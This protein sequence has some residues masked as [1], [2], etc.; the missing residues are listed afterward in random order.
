MAVEAGLLARMQFTGNWRD[1]QRRALD[2]F[3]AESIGRRIHVVAPPGSGKTVLGLELVRRLG[4]PPLILAPTRTIRDQW[5]SRLCPLFLPQRPAEQDISFSLEQAAPM[6]AITY[7]A[8]HGWWSD[9]D[10]S[11]F[12]AL[13]DR[14][15]REGPVTLVL[16]EAHHLRREW[17][18]ALQALVDALDDARIVALTATPP[19]DAPLG[20]WARYAAM[21]GPVDFEIGVPELV[22][23]GDLCPHQDHVIFSAP[24]RDT[25][26]LL[27][28]RRRGMAALQADLRADGDLLDYLAAHPWLSDP[29]RHA[30]QI[31]E[32]PEILSA[33]LVHFAAAGRRLPGAPL[34][35]LG[36][37]RRELPMPDA[38]WLEI[39][40]DA[41]LF[42]AP[43]VF[44]IGEP[45][46]KALRAVLHAHG[47][48]EGGAVRLGESRKS[49]T[50]MS[51]SL[52]KLDSIVTIARMEAQNLGADLRM[53]VLADHVR[54]GD[55][56]HAARSDY[57][58]AKPGV[59][60]IFHTL[61]RA[62]I[63]GQKLGVLTGSL[64]II[65][66]SAAAALVEM[67]DDHGV[68]AHDLRLFALPDCP[69]YLRL[70]AEGEGAR[71]TVQLI[72]ALFAA[73]HLTI[74]AGTQALLGEGWDAPAIN[75]LVLASNTAAFMASNQMRGRA[76]RVDPARPGKVANIW[77]LATVEQLP[78]GPIETWGQRL[79]WGYL[80]TGEAITSDLD[81]LQRR[82]RAFEGVGNVAST[83]IESGMARLG[84]RPGAGIAQANLLTFDRAHARSGIAECWRQSLGEAHARAHVRETASP[85]YAPQQLAWNDTLGWLGI[86]ALTTGLSAAAHEFL[87]WA[88]GG[89]AAAA[90]MA[91]AGA[92]ALASLPR[93]VQ[94][95]W[96]LFRNGSL[97]TSLAQ[98]GRV[99]I[100][101]LN[102]AG[103]LSKLE[104]ETAAL[105]LRRDLTGR[106][107]IAVLGVSRAA[108]RAFI[109]AMSEILGPVQN[110]RYLLERRSW[111]GWRM[112]SDYHAVPAVIARSKGGAERFHRSWR[113]HVGASR[114][115]F[116]RSPPGRIVLLRARARSFAAGFQRR[117]DRRSSWL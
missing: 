70:E 35:L 99:V 53:V 72:T 75:S 10:P 47:L 49:F 68:P 14:L 108:E 32:T 1:Y 84:I 57:V 44:A 103:V 9:A 69:D 36:L 42:R 100:G 76:I 96:L 83:Q 90:T 52:A 38:L 66:A 56:P 46:K 27:D 111:L 25:L 97:E 78:T 30:E 102:H 88:D 29:R 112:R 8:L 31:L 40:L 13:C 113:A 101:G 54:A 62:G 114:L 77:H 5:P 39:L 106:V 22:R 45:R 82:F 28:Q 59:V 51:R 3:D 11:R 63:A 33:I 116:T 26:A 86:A 92:A 61:R 93:L 117:V 71:C 98:V 65:P 4:R 48:I 79:A 41:F 55:L 18:N 67:G 87:A 81:L 20:E 91:L 95:A 6:T 24:D 7:Q 21:C 64:V 89:D 109:G 16:D 104:C 34:A 107:D 60:P 15:R 17:W 105:Q 43:H 94:S 37:N 110:P 115:V 73:G 2:Q 85:N 80:D 23:N 50:L 74:L 58:P 12:A 19:Y